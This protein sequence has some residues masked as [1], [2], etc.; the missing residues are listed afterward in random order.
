MN[1]PDDMPERAGLEP[2]LEQAPASR[3]ARRRSAR[4]PPCPSPSA[5]ACCGRPACRH[6]RTSPEACRDIA[7]SVRLAERR[8]RRRRRQVVL[9]AARPCR[10][11][12]GATEKPQWPMI[13]VVTPWRTLLSAFG[14]IG[15]V[16][17]E[18]V[19]MSMKPGATASPCAS[20][21]FRAGP[22]SFGPIADDAA[23][24]RSRR[25]LECPRGRCRRREARRGS[26]CHARQH[27]R[28]QSRCGEEERVDRA[29]P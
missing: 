28:H 11:R 13:S 24:A 20:T 6:S 22:S 9:A 8:P 15:S 12:H 4:G 1:R 23:V 18:C 7:G 25:R 10:A 19:L 5:A 14:L 16:K 2:I 17:S 29:A 26:E 21:V 3:R 27:S